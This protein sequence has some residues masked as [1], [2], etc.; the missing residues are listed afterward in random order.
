MFVEPLQ[1]RRRIGLAVASSLADFA[2]LV[3][4]VAS[5]RIEAPSPAPHLS[6]PFDMFMVTAYCDEGLLCLEDGEQAGLEVVVTAL[7]TRPGRFVSLGTGELA[8]ALLTPE[9]LLRLLRAPLRGLLDRRVP[10]DHS[11]S[12]KCAKQRRS[13]VS[14]RART[15]K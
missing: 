15:R 11:R 14:L 10:L 1:A 8:M 2:R 9:G 7:R 6:M 5:V 13:T 12:T 4:T 3:P